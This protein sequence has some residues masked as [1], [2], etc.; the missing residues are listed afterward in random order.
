[1]NENVYK[2]IGAGEGETIEFKKNERS[3]AESV[4]AMANTIGGCVLVGIDNQGNIVGIE[5][6]TKE[7][8]STALQSL[9]PSPKINIDHL[10]LERKNVIKIK[11]EKNDT[12]VFIGKRAYIRIGCSNRALSIDEMLERAVEFTNIKFDMQLSN[13]SITILN[14]KIIKW[15]LEN[16]KK[17]RGIPVRGTLNEN[18]R[19]IKAGINQNGKLKPTYGG[20]LFFTQDPADYI[21]SAKARVIKMRGNETE[22][23]K[24]LFGPVWK[25]ADDVYNHVLSILESVELRTGTRRKKIL[26]YPEG[27]IREAII[28]AFAH[29]NYL[30]DADIRIFL[31]E[32]SLIIRSP[33]SFPPA[34]D[35]KNPDHY[36]RNPLLCQY[37][38]DCGYIERYGFGILRILEECDAHPYSNVRFD[39]TPSKVDV[40][41][42]KK[43]VGIDEVDRKIIAIIKDHPMSSSE[44][45]S[46]VG[47]SKV[48]VLKRI[49]KLLV[50]MEVKKLGKGPG[51]RYYS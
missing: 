24:E 28:N 39:I 40:V 32:N 30:V 17:T 42:Y 18:L 3:V 4:C 47:L 16:R 20:I 26:I 25:L 19:K 46:N 22:M 10:E 1:M 38:Y 43:I 34:V 29:R 8:I 31:K 33:G 12:L 9:I 50:I 6:K 44:I 13:Q 41:F 27:A 14:K 23:I 48:S 15:Y 36:P 2:L 7:R 37:L 45:G 35:I 11:V 49:K 5:K 51:T 21:S